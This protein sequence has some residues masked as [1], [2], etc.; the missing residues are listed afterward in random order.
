MRKLDYGRTILFANGDKKIQL[1][2]LNI[3]PECLHRIIEI[4]SYCETGRNLPDRGSFG[5]AYGQLSEIEI[6]IHQYRYYP[7]F[8][9]FQGKTWKASGVAGS[10]ACIGPA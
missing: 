5:F 4:G 10:H 1:S 7:S 6:L 2:W 3:S 8:T 9:V